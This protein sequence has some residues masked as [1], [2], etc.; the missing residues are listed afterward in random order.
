MIEDGKVVSV[1]YPLKND[2]GEEIDAEQAF[3]L[4]PGDRLML[5]TDG[6]AEVEVAEGGLLGFDALRPIFSQCGGDGASGA[7]ETVL[8]NVRSRS[9]GPAIDDQTVV[10]VGMGRAAGG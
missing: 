5:Y 6:I 2:A 10:V 8:R 1:H 3:L 7:V 9:L 4:R